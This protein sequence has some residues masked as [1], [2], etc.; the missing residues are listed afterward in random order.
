MSENIESKNIESIGQPKFKDTNNKNRKI[1][2][3]EYDP[4]TK[5]LS[6]N[7]SLYFDN[8][9]MEVWEYKIGGYQVLDKYLKSHKG[10]ELDNTHIKHIQHIIKTLH[11]SLEIE[12]KIEKIKL[13]C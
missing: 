9:N 10:E 12:S 7:E 8:V 3:S 2:K 4:N 11:K 1:S 6:I 5:K 13:D